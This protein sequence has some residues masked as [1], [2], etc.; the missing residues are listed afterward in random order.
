M[1]KFA[2]YLLAIN[3]STH[4]GGLLNKKL[5]TKTVNALPATGERYRVWDTEI[6]GFHVR[7]TPKGKKVYVLAYRHHGIQKEITI[8]QHGNITAD[9]ARILAKKKA[10]LVADE[11]DVQAEK[12]KAKHK[13]KQEKVSSLQ[14]FIDGRYGLWASASLKSW[15]LS[16]QTVERDFKH[17]LSRPVAEITQWDMQK[18]VAQ[19]LKNG[20]KAT[21]VNR[22]V[23]IIKGI[24]SKAYEWGVITDNP[25]R[26]MKAVKT[27]DKARVRFLAADEEKRLRAELDARQEKQREERNSH[28]LWCE[29]RSLV[30]PEPLSGNFTDYLKP[31]VLL[32]INTGMRRG[33]LFNLEWSDVD[34]KNRIVTVEGL[35]AKSGKTRHLPL[36]DEAFAA[37]LVWRNETAFKTLVFPSPVN[38]ESEEKLNNIKRSWGG[39]LSGAKITNFR[40][41]DL[42]H[43]FAS[44]LVMAGVD[45]N[46][47]RELLGHGEIATTLRY[48]HL[49]PEHKAAAVAMLNQTK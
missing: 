25:L 11:T 45:L 33:E 21:T 26:G 15:P 24:V 7:V 41:H 8:D 9:E 42:R 39:L 18:W 37:L 10:G 14:A 31:M 28:I 36:N 48:A 35:T 16:K 23:A 22:R 12:L 46:T 47:V 34:L 3:I 38:T 43:H 20:S 19:A 4:G 44:Q 29:A 32:A 13:A 6:K 2:G 17:L 30:K 40:F 5:T 1:L 49:A 27:D